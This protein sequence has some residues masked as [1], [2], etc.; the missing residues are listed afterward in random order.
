MHLHPLPRD[1]RNPR[2]QGFSQPLSPAF[3]DITSALCPHVLILYSHATS[4][5][6]K[7][8]HSITLPSQM[9][10][11]SVTGMIEN[12]W[13][14][15]PTDRLTSTWQTALTQA[16]ILSSSLTHL[17]MLHL[18]LPQISPSSSRI[19]LPFLSAKGS[20]T[21][22]PCLLPYHSSSSLWCTSSPIIPLPTLSMK[23]QWQ[24]STH[25]SRT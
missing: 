18:P 3:Q 16:S 9:L 12:H 24:P 23:N 4:S 5:L 2:T 6:S 21:T 22:F 8:Y 17:S 1:P 20:S 25:Y 15:H 11:T 14:M 13:N 19:L 10:H 7:S